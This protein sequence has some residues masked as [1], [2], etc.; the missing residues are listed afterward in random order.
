MITL[1]TLLTTIC[2]SGIAQTDSSITRSFEQSFNIDPEALLDINLQYSSVR[3]ENWDSSAVAIQGNVEALTTD[4][5]K[6]EDIFNLITVDMYSS[7]LEV[8]LSTIVDAEYEER[9]AQPFRI[10]F[11]IM[12]PKSIGIL[13]RFDFC[14]VAIPALSGPTDLKYN[15]SAVGADSLS[16]N[17]TEVAGRY[18]Q[19][20]IKV[21]AGNLLV[22]Q[23][24][25]LKV[26]VIN[27]ST[28]I[29]NEYGNAKID[30][31][32][33][34]CKMLSFSNDF[35]EIDARLSPGVEYQLKVDSS[36][37]TLLFPE[38][39]EEVPE[40]DPSKETSWKGTIGSGEKAA[41]LKIDNE[42]GTITFSW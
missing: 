34:S 5:A 12:I 27:D 10:N 22:N 15:Y 28:E 37:G 7:P 38:E 17:K 24:G 39:V 41:E 2:M 30:S 16:F 31:V 3:F 21:F 14:E 29:I 36:Y 42:F 25:D 4:S 8:G 1:T 23:Y 35:G 19:T 18:S 6:A 20:D 32:A 33:Q 13:G 9:N 26:G 40:T 11:K